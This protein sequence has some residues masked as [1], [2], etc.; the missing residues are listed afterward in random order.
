MTRR[1]A[2]PDPVLTALIPSAGRRVIGSVGMALIAAL[3][4]QMGL[5]LPGSRPVARALCLILGGV[6]LVMAAHF[7]LATGAVLELTATELR[8]VR[9]AGGRVRR[10]AS[11]D[12]IASVDRGMTMLR[13]TSGFVIRLAEPAPLALATGLWWRVGRRVGVGGS[14]AGYGSRLMADTLARLLRERG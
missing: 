6:G 10:I 13:P 7:W 3:L 8:E 9:R 14:V 11:L 12:Q 1:P 4:V 5:E 2:A